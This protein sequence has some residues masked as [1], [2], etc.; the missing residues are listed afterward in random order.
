MSP[1]G[2]SLIRF[3]SP[4]FT[5]NSAPLRSQNFVNKGFFDREAQNTANP[6]GFANILTKDERKSAFTKRCSG[7]TAHPKEEV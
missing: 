7:L 5:Q 1:I 4:K 3:A 6:D 2:D